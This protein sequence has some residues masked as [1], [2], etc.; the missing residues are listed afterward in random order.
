MDKVD[1]IQLSDSALAD[2]LH[3]SQ[4]RGLKNT[5]DAR[6][7]IVVVLGMHRSGTS[8]C[9]HVLSALGIDMADEIGQGPGNED[10]HWERWEIVG[11]HDQLLMALN[12][13]YG[14][15]GEYD[16]RHDLELP[17]GWHAAPAVRRIQRGLE[18]FLRSRMRSDEIFGFKDPRT[19]RFLPLWL[20]IFERLKLEPYFV[21]CIRDPVDVALSLNRRDGIPQL[22]GEYRWLTYNVESLKYLHEKKLIIINY[23]EWLT[24]RSQTIERIRAFIMPNGGARI[25]DDVLEIIKPGMN[26]G[27]SQRSQ[28]ISPIVRDFFALL[29]L[30]G[31][32]TKHRSAIAHA[33][34]AFEAHRSASPLGPA[35]LTSLE[36]EKAVQQRAADAQVQ[37]EKLQSENVQMTD[38]LAQLQV[39]FDML[40]RSTNENS[41]HEVSFPAALE[42]GAEMKIEGEFAAN[43]V[44]ESMVS[45]YAILQQEVE[46][47]SRALLDAKTL[48]NAR[49]GWIAQEDVT[50]PSLTVLC[51]EVRT[52]SSKAAVALQA[53]ASRAA[54]LEESISTH[55]VTT[56]DR[57]R[58]RIL[59]RK[60]AM[61]EAARLASERVIQQ[62]I[63]ESSRKQG[64]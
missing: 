45:K 64:R 44:F 43:S 2:A 18:S 15:P 46:V 25:T 53:A 42:S 50:A 62:Q 8:L 24:E 3:D 11:L 9:S 4:S 63:P 31:T 38:Q 13:P 14:P 5:V 37:L 54:H 51:E 10:G 27:I 6:R 7:P 21:L 29:K 1:M 39:Q 36:R 59:S 60:L 26:H 17:V 16:P 41:Q 12:R 23:D 56:S 48:L 47:A 28:A 49:L 55:E 40:E 19:S 52:L 35:L 22:A 33:I 30:W 32:D 57:E 34:A 58:I 61:L 20:R